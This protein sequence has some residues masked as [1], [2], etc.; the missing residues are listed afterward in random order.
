MNTKHTI[1]EHITWAVRHAAVWAWPIIA[2][3]ITQ[4]TNTWSIDEFALLWLFGSMLIELQ[5]R[6][7]RVK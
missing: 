5:D 3:A 4:Y 7:K 1:R 6:N 2:L